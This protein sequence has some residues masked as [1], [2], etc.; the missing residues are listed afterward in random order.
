MNKRYL[1]IGCGENILPKPFENLDGRELEGV[2]YISDAFPLPQ[3]EDETFDLVYASHILEHFSRNQIESIITE[4]TR[5]LKTDGTLRL[6]VPSFENAIKIYQKTGKLE[7]V[8]GPVIGGQT[9]DYEF[10]YCIFDKRTLTAVMKKSGLTAIHP[11]IYQRTIHAD[12]WDFSQSETC[13]IQVSLNLEGR[14]RKGGPLLEETE[15]LLETKK[16]KLGQEI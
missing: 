2:D 13:D 14:K 9:Y 15:N 12:Y 6:S 4:W 10:H 16:D 5:I 1:H 11:W 7:N 8:I 3:F